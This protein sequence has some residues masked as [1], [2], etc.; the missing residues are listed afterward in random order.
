V[1][2]HCGVH[3]RVH[4]TCAVQ[5]PGVSL[6]DVACACFT[7]RA[8]LLERFPPVAYTGYRRRYWRRVLLPATFQVVELSI[9]SNVAHE[10]RHHLSQ[11][12]AIVV[13]PL[14]LVNQMPQVSIRDTVLG[15]LRIDL[16]RN[17]VQSKSEC[18]RVC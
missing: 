1:A 7:K 17:K 5:N 15:I 9:V 2:A 16:L 14:P 12:V 8:R 11:V 10:L 13:A 4:C 3:C 18:L 6:R